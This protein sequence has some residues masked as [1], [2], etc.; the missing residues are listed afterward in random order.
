VIRACVAAAPLLR[1]GSILG[2]CRRKYQHPASGC[3]FPQLAQGCEI[4]A[5]SFKKQMYNLDS[6]VKWLFYFSDYGEQVVFFIR[7]ES[8][9]ITLFDVQIL[10]IF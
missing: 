7:R 3:F 6:K 9:K 5:I 10:R 8:T 2:G 1:G 4:Y